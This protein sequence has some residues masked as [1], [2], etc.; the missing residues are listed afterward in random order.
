MSYERVPMPSRASFIGPDD[1]AASI[2]TDAP[3]A[4]RRFSLVVAEEALAKMGG[5]AVE[6]VALRLAQETVDRHQDEIRR[7]V[8]SYLNDREWAEP[9]IRAAISAS[10]RE[11]VF[12][13]METSRF[14]T[15]RS[16]EK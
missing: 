8:R 9:I 16:P 2:A 12:G 4:G 6:H 15:D 1:I 13:A 3:R 10:V 11:W 7:V 5:A 14:A